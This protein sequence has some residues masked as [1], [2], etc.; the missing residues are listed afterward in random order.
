MFI[1]AWFQC[2]DK[3]FLT[4]LI[5]LGFEKDSTLAFDFSLFRDI[6]ES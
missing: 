2:P 4:L 6:K 1:G 3:D 5:K